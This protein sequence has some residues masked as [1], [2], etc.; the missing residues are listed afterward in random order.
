VPDRA[1]SVGG[2]QESLAVG[3]AGIERSRLFA[4]ATIPDSQGG[5]ES[6]A[7]PSSLPP[8]ADSVCLFSSD[9]NAEADLDLLPIDFAQSTPDL[10]ASLLISSDI[11]V[12]EPAVVNSTSSAASS[13]APK[14]S[15]LRSEG[16]PVLPLRPVGSSMT[17]HPL[18]CE[19]GPMLGSS[20][21]RRRST[22]R[23]T[24]PHRQPQDSQELDSLLT[25]DPIISTPTPRANKVCT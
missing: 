11:P 23:L 19:T 7:F 8:S 17:V 3:R 4:F 6:V 25:R 10:D 13:P 21:L 5:G 20:H 18:S 15:F 1:T 2:N 9:E 14:I 12:T 24:Q 22:S 16:R